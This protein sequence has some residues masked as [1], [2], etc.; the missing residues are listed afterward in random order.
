MNLLVRANE[1]FAVFSR[2]ARREESPA[3]KNNTYATLSTQRHF[4]YYFSAAECFF[5]LFDIPRLFA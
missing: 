2:R 3:P 5:V 1:T 4:N